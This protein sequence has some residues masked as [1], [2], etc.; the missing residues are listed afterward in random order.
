MKYLPKSAIIFSL[1]FV[2]CAT[3]QLGKMSEINTERVYAV[4]FNKMWAAVVHALTDGDSNIKNIDKESGFINTEWTT[5]SGIGGLDYAPKIAHTPQILL[6]TWTAC[7]YRWS[8]MVTTIDSNHTSINAQ[9]KIEGYESNVS[10][11]WHACPSKGVLEKEFF[12][13]LDTELGLVG[14]V[15][16]KPYLGIFADMSYTGAG[17]KIIG[18]TENSS[19]F[20]AGVQKGDIIIEFNGVPVISLVSLKEAINATQIGEIVFIAVL[21]GGKEMTLSTKMQAK[22]IENK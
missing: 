8:I 17:V 14:E 3:F 11:R 1:L 4:G 12:L 7:R 22:P 6:A 18:I 13:T 21:R 20:N 2:S 15:V 9:A 16:A 10:Y 19:A 5:V